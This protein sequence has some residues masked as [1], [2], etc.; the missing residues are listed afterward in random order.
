LNRSKHFYD[1]GKVLDVP[2]NRLPKSMN[3]AVISAGSAPIPAPA[4]RL[5]G[6][7]ILLVIVALIELIHSSVG[8]SMLLGDMTVFPGPGI[9]GALLKLHMATHPVL[10]LAALI[11]AAIGR[12]RHAVMVLGAVV[13]TTWLSIMPSV[14]LHG[15]GAGSGTALTPEQVV[16]FPLMG[17]CAIALAVRNQWLWLATALVSIPTFMVSLGFVLF[18]ITVA[19]VG[20]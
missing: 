15:V 20:F 2:F 19:I 1:K 5:L 9:R 10:A 11:L 8:A 13:L 6:L 7:R 14:V 17:A 4:L 3:P 12:A 18:T 16:T